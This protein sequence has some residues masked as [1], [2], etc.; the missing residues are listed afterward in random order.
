[1]STSTTCYRRLPAPAR[2][3]CFPPARS[4]FSVRRASCFRLSDLRAATVWYRTFFVFVPAFDGAA[5]LT[6][7]PPGAAVCGF[8]SARAGSRVLGGA[9]GDAARDELGEPAAG[10]TAE[11]P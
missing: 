8:F 6:S 5:F 9:A 7:F 2:P 3:R 10:A 11:G 1:M 4:A